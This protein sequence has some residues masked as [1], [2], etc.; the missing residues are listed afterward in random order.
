MLTES[1]LE[2]CGGGVVRVS[3]GLSS[4]P[5]ASTCG[6][7]CLVFLSASFIPTVTL[8]WITQP[9]SQE[10]ERETERERE[11][12]VGQLTHA[13]RRFQMVQ[14]DTHPMFSPQRQTSD[15]S[16]MLCTE[17]WICTAFCGASGSHP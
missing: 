8:L 12:H 1:F 14:R 4:I 3:S 5:L 9:Q 15:L 10:R 7:Q 13:E 16:T 2:D 11:R 6:I 17:S